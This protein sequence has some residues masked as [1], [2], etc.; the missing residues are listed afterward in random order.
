MGFA[1]LP[2]LDSSLPLAAERL[3]RKTFLLWAKE[4]TFRQIR[5]LQ[6]RREVC[7]REKHDGE[8]KACTLE[9]VMR[10][11]VCAGTLTVNAL[12]LLWSCFPLLL[13]PLILCHS[14]TT[15]VLSVH[16]P[17]VPRP[18]TIHVLW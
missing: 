10:S 3:S 9:K 17:C 7:R 1:P 12:M 2:S 4:S 11:K 5:R 16:L 18:L 8:E 13:L 14:Q 15:G 6:A